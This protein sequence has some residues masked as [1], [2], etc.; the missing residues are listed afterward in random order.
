MKSAKLIL[1]ESSDNEANYYLSY[2]NQDGMC[3]ANGVELLKYEVKIGGRDVMVIVVF[4]SGYVEQLYFSG[5][6]EN[7]IISEK[8]YRVITA[9]KYD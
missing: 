1:F 2:D 4:R 3:L 9:N 6:S 8:C 7:E 5:I